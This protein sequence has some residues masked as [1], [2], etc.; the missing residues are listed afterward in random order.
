MILVCGM[1]GLMQTIFMQLQSIMIT[2]SWKAS[3][4]RLNHIQSSTSKVPVQIKQLQSHIML[5]HLHVTDTWAACLNMASWEALI[6]FSA[7]TEAAFINKKWSWHDSPTFWPSD[8]L[9]A[10]S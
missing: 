7:S 4:P 6:A 8:S 1:F 2:V 9:T 3:L 10:W 5:L